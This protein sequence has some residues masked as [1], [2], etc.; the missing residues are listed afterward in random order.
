MHP[1]FVYHWPALLISFIAAFGWGAVY[2]SFLAVKPWSEAMGIKMDDSCKP[3]PA[4]MKR[5]FG[6]QVIGLIFTVFVLNLFTQLWR[7]S[8][9][10]AAGLDGSSFGY[11]WNAAFFTW[12]GFY[13]PLQLNKVSWESRPMKLFWINAGHDFVNLQIISQILAYWRGN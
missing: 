9:W 5:S 10:S 1:T 11:A 13:V 3:D 8:V 4:T 7:P 12:L 2:Y 6:L